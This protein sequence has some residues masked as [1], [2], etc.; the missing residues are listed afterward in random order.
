VREIEEGL[1]YGNTGFRHMPAL[2]QYQKNGETQVKYAEQT[3][4]IDV[5][6]ILK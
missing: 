2:L 3:D 6:P 1:E 4:A 5:R